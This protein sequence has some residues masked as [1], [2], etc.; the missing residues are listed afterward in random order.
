VSFCVVAA[1]RVV[2]DRNPKK[3]RVKL[4]SNSGT[5]DPLGGRVVL[6]RVGFLP[7]FHHPAIE[8][9]GTYEARPRGM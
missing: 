7:C 1:A 5:H 9:T 8:K 3:P 2:G 6:K 4:E